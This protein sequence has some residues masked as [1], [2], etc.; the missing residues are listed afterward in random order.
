MSHPYFMNDHEELRVGLSLSLNAFFSHRG[1]TEACGSAH[2]QAIL[3]RTFMSHHTRFEQ[4]HVNDVYIFC[5][6]KHDSDDGKLSMWRGYG[7]NGLG[8]AMVIDT[9]RLNLNPKSPLMLANVNYASSEQ[10]HDWIVSKLDE[11]AQLLKSN[12]IHDDHLYIATHY[13]YERLKQA[14]IFTK[15]SGFIEEDEYRLVYMRE[16]DTEKTMEPFFSYHISEAGI[17]PKLKLKLK[18]SNGFMAS[19][20]S[21]E[22]IVSSIILGPS[23]SSPLAAATFKRMLTMSGKGSLADKVKVSSTPFRSHG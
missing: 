16:R 1:I 2:R 7:G 12:P 15:H 20:Q 14:A 19:G 9:S 21:L 6:S 3:Y 23:H 10:R 13:L 8:A 11:F 22:N 4:E 5:L 17:H 18:D